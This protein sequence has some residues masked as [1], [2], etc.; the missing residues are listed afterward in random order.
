MISWPEELIS[1]LARR[2]CVVF[3]GAGVSMNSTNA[4]G[5][6][7]KSWEIF[8]RDSMRE[9]TPNRHINNLINKFDY[10]TACEIIKSKLGRERFNTIIL[11][12]FLTPRY[13]PAPIHAHI[14]NL[15]SRIIMSP[16]FDKIYETYANNIASGSIRVKS[17]CE[18]DIAETIR[19]PNRLIIKVH[20]TIDAPDQM[21]FSRAEYSNA[22]VQNRDFYTIFEALILTHTFLFIGCGLNDPDIKLLLE[23]YNYKF[24]CARNH[25]FVIPN[26]TI[27]HDE[28]EVLKGAMNLKFITYS[29]DD[30]HQEL[31][32]SLSELAEITSIKR[33]ELAASQD[34]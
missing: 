16:N 31:T 17:Y 4:A 34:W 27:H 11:D 2:K 24:K 26:R 8:L 13:L 25:Y 18:P 33:N 15:D 7:P 28:A 12:E 10:L 1:D 20:G 29:S 14:Y 5:R 22:K 32:D 9:I 19:R 30:N 23:D 21:I 6:R 3:L